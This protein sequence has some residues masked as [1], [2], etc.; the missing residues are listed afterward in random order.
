MLNQSETLLPLVSVVIPSHN[1]QRY[2]EY[3]ILSVINQDY[4]NIELIIIDDG[5][6]DDSTSKIQKLLIQCQN[7]FV[8]FE[9][10][11]RENIGLSETLNEGLIWSRGLYFCTLASDDLFDIK[12]ISSLVNKF[13]ILNDSYSVIFGDAAFIDHNGKQLFLSH[14]FLKSKDKDLIHTN[15]FLEYFASRK[16]I[17]YINPAVFGSYES[18]L[19]GNYLP[20]MACL[21]KTNCLKQVGGFSKNIRIEDWDIWL[22][23]SKKYLFYFFPNVV[24]FYRIHH[25]NSITSEPEKLLVDSLTLLR[26]EKK[27]ALNNGYSKQYYHRQAISV[28]R[29]IQLKPLNFIFYI[30][31][32]FNF[33]FILKVFYVIKNILR[34]GF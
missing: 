12:K 11:S 10:R 26:R 7:R 5:S 15:S 34:Q 2:I 31:Y 20:A 28:L 22:K 13:S 8:R 19:Q 14:D 3:S 24:S 1:H 33:K 30:H 18:L 29:L 4:E 16:N 27:Y 32:F 17:S 21:I 23:L 9:Y 25:L 6:K